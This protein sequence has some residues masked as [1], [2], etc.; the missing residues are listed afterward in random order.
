MHNVLI[1]Y[2]RNWSVT[3]S[4]N[5]KDPTENKNK[6]PTQMYRQKTGPPYFMLDLF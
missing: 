1:S 5:H 6:D 3:K 4:F 2:N